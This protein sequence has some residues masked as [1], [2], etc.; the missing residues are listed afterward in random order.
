MRRIIYTL[1]TNNCIDDKYRDLSIP[2][3]ERYCDSV[4]AEFKI[5]TELHP[6]I[7]NPNYFWHRLPYALDYIN[8]GYDQVLHLD[9]DM[10]IASSAGN[11]FQEMSNL[12]GDVFAVKGHQWRLNWK[13]RKS[14]LHIPE[15]FR[16]FYN[17]GLVGF[18][19][20]PGAVKFLEAYEEISNQDDQGST[21]NCLFYAGLDHL[22][23]IK[24]GAFKYEQPLLLASAWYSKVPIT[25][26]QS[27]WNYRYSKLNKHTRVSICHYTDKKHLMGS[28]EDKFLKY[29]ESY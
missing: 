21:S 3:I 20:T 14:L 15:N 11:I 4:G 26:L 22:D 13:V 7:L 10:L 23:W 19:N 24:Y 12:G 18:F 9:L 28:P 1:A 27:H 6:R 16:N 8:S 2:C 29:N 17:G 5:E 25:A